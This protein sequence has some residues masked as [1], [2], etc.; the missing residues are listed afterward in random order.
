MLLI[1]ILVFAEIMLKTYF[2]LSG[3]FSVDAIKFH[4]NGFWF[5]SKN[6]CRKAKGKFSSGVLEKSGFRLESKK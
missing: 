2:N 1:H 6:M 3:I 5:L 4:L